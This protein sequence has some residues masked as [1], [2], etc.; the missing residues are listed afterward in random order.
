MKVNEI[1]YRVLSCEANTPL[2]NVVDMMIERE[3][4]SILVLQEGR[5]AGIFTERDALR[6]LSSKKSIKNLKIKDVMQEPKYMID[7]NESVDEAAR[8][9]E[10]NNIR[11]LPVIN[12]EGKAVGLVTSNLISKNMKFMM[13]KG[14]ASRVGGPLLSTLMNIYRF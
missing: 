3:R 7:E 6:L 4:A 12:K 11:R 8:I 14:M 2:H 9:L 13:A 5:P 1:M 10:E